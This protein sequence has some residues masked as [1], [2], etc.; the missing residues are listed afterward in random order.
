MAELNS[1]NPAISVDTYTSENMFCICSQLSLDDIL[2]RQLEEPLP[3]SEMIEFY[4]SCRTGC[5][6]CIPTLRARAKTKDIF[7]EDQIMD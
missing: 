5:G 1:A 2:K 3:F 7:F 4:T 6:S